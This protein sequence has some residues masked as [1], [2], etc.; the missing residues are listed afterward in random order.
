MTAERTLNP[1]TRDPGR[2]TRPSHLTPAI[3]ELQRGR[4]TLFI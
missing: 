3:R 4:I 1:A 2:Q